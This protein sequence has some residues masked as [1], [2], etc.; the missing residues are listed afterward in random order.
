MSDAYVSA[1]AVDV[2]AP[3]FDEPTRYKRQ[4]DALRMIN[5]P[6]A[7]WQRAGLLC[8]KSVGS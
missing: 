8:L 3:T 6:L 1:T 2:E 7:Q 5:A 4:V